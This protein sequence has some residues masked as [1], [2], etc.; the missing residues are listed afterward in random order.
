[1]ALSG[2]GGVGRW[3]PAL[4][5]GQIDKVPRGEHAVA[6][7]PHEVV[8]PRRRGDE[9]RRARKEDARVVEQLVEHAHQRTLALRQQ[10]VASQLR[11]HQMSIAGPSQ[12][13]MIC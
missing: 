8:G 11:N 6:V 4:D 1:M 2:G 13:K 12:T 5:E 3:L 7:A 9:R 10:L